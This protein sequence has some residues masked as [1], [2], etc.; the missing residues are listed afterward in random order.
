MIA[1]GSLLYS[2]TERHAVFPVHLLSATC[3]STGNVCF[4][5][6]NLEDEIYESLIYRFDTEA[7]YFA[8]FA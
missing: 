8:E 2:F 1:A 3:Q 6:T 7:A 5:Q 4:Q